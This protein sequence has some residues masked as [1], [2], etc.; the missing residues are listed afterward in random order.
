MS[1]FP[2]F[3][4]VSVLATSSALSP[5]LKSEV[6]G[7][8]SSHELKISYLLNPYKGYGND[9]H[10]F[11][12]HSADERLRAMEGFLTLNE[13]GLFLAARGGAGA[14]DLLSPQLL[15][16]MEVALKGKPGKIL[17][18]YSDFTLLLSVFESLESLTLIHGPALL[19][20]R[21]ELPLEVRDQNLQS[22]LDV[23]RGGTLLVPDSEIEAVFPDRG[24][25]EGEVFGGNLSVLCSLLGTPY[26]P[27]ISK[28][29]ILLLEDVGEAPHK[30]HRHLSHLRAA[31]V[32]SNVSGVLLGSF[33]GC[34][35]PEKK[36]PST[37]DVIKRF[38]ETEAIPVFRTESI[39][40]G[41][42]NRSI[43]LY[44][45]VQ[46]SEE[47]LHLDSPLRL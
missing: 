22:L 1:Q 8:L 12:A 6:E 37:L 45:K 16:R 40:H 36:P 14:Y 7:Y 43:P 17:C 47:G 29:R 4:K 27:K 2:S 39:G 19:G 11:A 38:F 26:F 35:H 44:R 42:I 34:H 32:F 30:I 15:S 28:K 23:L 3:Q 21:A 10:L 13:T 46:L 5:N 9:E 24:N 33:Y 31:S 20:F 25:V 18:G 41:P